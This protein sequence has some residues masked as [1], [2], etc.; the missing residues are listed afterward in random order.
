MQIAHIGVSNPPQSHSVRIPKSSLSG[1]PETLDAGTEESIGLWLPAQVGF[2]KKPL[3]TRGCARKPFPAEPLSYSFI[4]ASS[5]N[6]SVPERHIFQLRSECAWP[7]SPRN[8]ARS[9]G[10]LQLSRPGRVPMRLETTFLSRQAIFSSL[11]SL[12]TAVLK[13]PRSLR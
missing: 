5:G 1:K 8:M 10:V 7:C 4:E 13:S 2:W 6:W 9:V 12:A 11:A 3:H